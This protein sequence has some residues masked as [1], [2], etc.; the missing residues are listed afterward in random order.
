M[1]Y[2]QNMIIFGIT[3]ACFGSFLN[4]IAHRSVQGRSWWG[5]ERS[6]CESCG[7]VLTAWELVPVFSWLIQ[8]G[9]CRSCGKKISVRYIFIEI[10]CAVM[11]MMIYSHWGLS[12]ACLICCVSSCGLIIN[13]LTDFESGDIFD[14]F[15][16]TPGILGI[17]I[18]IA[19]GWPALLDGLEGAL[20]GFGI[21]AAIILI[22][23]G[24][25]GWG[26]ASF[27]GGMGAV[28]GLKFT[29][30]AFYLGIM[31]GGLWVIILM[32][33][34]KVKWGRG[35]TVPLV[36]FLA[37]GCFITMIY[38]TEIFSLLASRFTFTDIFAPSWPFVK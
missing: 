37:V 25:M 11:A 9:K 27:M 6:K 2:I 24:G 13:S 5:S 31:T 15:A 1:M 22:S 18:R 38:G 32:L 7:H 28:L 14:V 30:L 36:P 35:D 29:L 19:G 26:D 33:A 12:W 4:V 17:I 20:L 34:G 3:G 21:F 23:R 8:R 10:L 16:I